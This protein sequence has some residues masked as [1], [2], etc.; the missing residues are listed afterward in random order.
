M[1]SSYPHN[2]TEFYKNSEHL[3]NTD[4]AQAVAWFDKQTQA[5]RFFILSQIAPNLDEASILDVGAGLCDFYPYLKDHHSDFKYTALEYHGP[6]VKELQKRYPE[7]KVI[8]NH[9]LNAE[10]GENS[11]DYVFASGALTIK[12]E[13]T[14]GNAKACIQKMFRVCKKG[15]AFNM[16][17]DLSDQKIDSHTLQYFSPAEIFN[18][19][20][21]LTP[22][23]TLRHDYL[24]GD[25]SIYL[26]K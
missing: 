4:P 17:S 13:D 6:F 15:V 25:F 8:D 21:T 18:Y 26:Y 22:F 16:L 12:S 14:L 1:T 19:G 2:I 7:I 5:V 3:I 10:L 9:F 24:K 11:F 23:V 20:K